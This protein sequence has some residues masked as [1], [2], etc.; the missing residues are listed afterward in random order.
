MMRVPGAGAALL[1]TLLGLA[2]PARAAVVPA[3]TKDPLAALTRPGDRVTLSDEAHVT[4]WAHASDE[5]PVRTEPRTGAKT[6]TTLRYETEDDLPE[7]YLVLDARLDGKGVPWLHVRL[8]LRP[9][10]RTG[11]VPA[12]RLSAL[13]VVRTRLTIDLS[14]R[15]LTLTRDGKTLLTSRVG[16]GAPGTPTPQGRFW[17]RELL[18]GDGATYG[19][20]AFGTAAYSRLSDWPGGGV[21]GIHGTD[22]PDLIPGAPSHGCV[23]VPNDAIRRLRTLMPIG[24]PVRIVP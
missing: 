2:A 16:V 7:V 15:A 20:W 13:Y 3:T 14:D 11:W 24:T 10:G 21:V 18:K 6:I 1:L 19:P 8:P 17:I 23:R 22:R 4:R 9:N 5:Y 12:D